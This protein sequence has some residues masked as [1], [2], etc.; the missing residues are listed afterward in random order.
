MQELRTENAELRTEVIQL[1]TE[2]TQL[3]AENAELKET[4]ANLVQQVNTL[5]QRVNNLEEINAELRKEN[6]ELR[7]R[8]DV[9]EHRIVVLEQENTGLK[10]SNAKLM[11]DNIRIKQIYHE[12]RVITA[13]SDV[14]GYEKHN[15]KNPV[16]QDFPLKRLKENRHR[17]NHYLLDVEKSQP[18]IVMMREKYLYER[19]QEMIENKTPFID[20]IDTY[21]QDISG[22]TIYQ[23]MSILKQHVDASNIVIS[24]SEKEFLDRWWRAEF[25]D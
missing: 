1:R 3:R 24:D 2:N 23:L 22:N 13:L 14:L 18:D 4:V 12:E 7:Q 8:V 15:I 9:L 6:T 17:I 10:Q 21:I 16:F 11:K 25:D 20:L 5:L 19:L